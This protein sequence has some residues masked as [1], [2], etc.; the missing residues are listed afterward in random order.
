MAI[1]V[2]FTVIDLAVCCAASFVWFRFRVIETTGTFIFYGG[3]DSVNKQC[4]CADGDRVPEVQASKVMQRGT[5]K[6]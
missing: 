3:D 4:S 6:C 1:V 2:F 5:N